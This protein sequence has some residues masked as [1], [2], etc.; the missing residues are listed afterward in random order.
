M[1]RTM[2]TTGRWNGKGPWRVAPRAR[3]V[4]L[5]LAT[6]A[7]GAEAQ[8]HCPANVVGHTNRGNTWEGHLIG[9]RPV[10]EETTRNSGT[11]SGTVSGNAGTPAGGG[12]AS[13]SGT[14]GS[15]TKRETTTYNVGTYEFEN[16]QRWDVNCS[17]LMAEGRVK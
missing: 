7:Q 2:K 11:A 9:E 12:G 16:G 6:V 17:T 10:T 15:T 3:G 1:Q 8:S 14:T 5:L 13:V 4:L